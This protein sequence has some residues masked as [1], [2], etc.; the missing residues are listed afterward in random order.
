MFPVMSVLPLRFSSRTRHQRGGGGPPAT[1]AAGMP[2]NREYEH[3]PSRW[4]EPRRPYLAPKSVP[5]QQVRCRQLR[6]L[7]SPYDSSLAVVTIRTEYEMDRNAGE[8]QSL[9]LC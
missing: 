1:N 7:R 3:V 5:P 8:F 4:A 2:R 9:R 6:W